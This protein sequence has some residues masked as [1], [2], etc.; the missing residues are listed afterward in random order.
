M[1]H[2]VDKLRGCDLVR[3]LSSNIIIVHRHRGHL[4]T[5]IFVAAPGRRRVIGACMRPRDNCVS[6][7][8]RMCRSTL[9]SVTLENRKITSHHVAVPFFL[10]VF[11]YTL[12]FFFFLSSLIIKP[13]VTARDAGNVFSSFFPRDRITLLHANYSAYEVRQMQLP[14]RGNVDDR[15][16]RGCDW[17][18]NHEYDPV[19]A[20]T[21]FTSLALTASVVGA[22]VVSRDVIRGRMLALN[23]LVTIISTCSE[24]SSIWRSLT[25]AHSLTDTSIR[26]RLD[27]QR[28]IK[29][30]PSVLRVCMQ[31][32]RRALGKDYNKYAFSLDSYHRPG[33]VICALRLR[34]CFSED[35][36]DGPLDEYDPGSSKSRSIGSNLDS[37]AFCRCKMRDGFVSRDGTITLFQW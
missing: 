4:S 2:F 21:C 29:P 31:S 8:I 7:K 1:I 9:V 3:V 16:H 34:F 32:S 11:Y 5:N 26:E 37:P 28:L 18:I 10:P 33:N 24:A 19:P 20:N 15:L 12:F 25:V 27:I 6:A 22:N 13:Y 36:C 14:R 30:P 23:K 35:D 17:N